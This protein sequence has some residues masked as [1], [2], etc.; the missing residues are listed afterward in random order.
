MDRAAWEEH[1]VRPRP[2]P[3]DP[4]MREAFEAASDM[5]R[6]ADEPLALDTVLKHRAR[7]EASAPS[8]DQVIGDRPLTLTEVEGPGPDGGPA[9]TVA[10]FRPRDLS[11]STGAIYN[12]H[13]GGMFLGNRFSWI[14]DLLDTAVEL[15]VI[16][17]SVEYRR[18]PEHPHPAPAEDCYAG[19]ELVAARAGQ[20]GIDPQRILAMGDSA[21]GALAAAVAL[22]SRDRGGPRLAGVALKSPMLDDRNDRV[23]NC[24]YPDAGPW[25]ASMNAVGWAAL[26]GERAGGPDV[27]AYAAPSRA[28]DLSGLPPV[29]I[30]VGAAEALRDESVDWASRIWEAGGQAELHVWAGAFHGFT[31]D[32]PD[33]IASRAARAV[34]RSWVRRILGVG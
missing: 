21:G 28:I 25:N 34:R 13:G 23:S 5:A 11:G 29:Y 17:A 12:T 32:A 3:V 4:E 8:I 2:V 30:E 9:V 33:S 19:L 27:P 7:I 18:G 10:V 6:G 24:Q 26:L 22:M 1:P 15:G 31:G 20:L 16:A 14:D